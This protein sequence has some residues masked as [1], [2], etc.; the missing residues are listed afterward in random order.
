MDYDG[1][2]GINPYFL[3]ALDEGIGSAKNLTKFHQPNIIWAQIDLQ[4]KHV[5]FLSHTW[6]NTKFVKI[7]TVSL[8]SSPKMKHHD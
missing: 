4:E 1:C 8:N 5:Q 7:S 2:D 3:T 6:Q